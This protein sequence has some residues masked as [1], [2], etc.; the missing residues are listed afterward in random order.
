VA[1]GPG[2][3]SDGVTGARV[4]QLK[5]VIWC[6]QTPLGVLTRKPRRFGGP[7]LPISTTFR[8]L[9]GSAWANNENPVKLDLD[10]LPSQLTLDTKRRLRLESIN[11][12]PA[13]ANQIQPQP[14]SHNQHRQAHALPTWRLSSKLIP[15]VVQA[16]PA[17]RH[18]GTR[19]SACCV[20]APA[21]VDRLTGSQLTVT[22]FA[23]AAAAGATTL[24]AA[25][26]SVGR[27]FRLYCGDTARTDWCE[28]KG[29]FCKFEATAI[30][31]P[32]AM[33]CLTTCSCVC[34][35]CDSSA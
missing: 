35:T 21:P 16:H 28:A 18:E 6:G 20:P 24:A 5:N 29:A 19:A 26:A 3:S 33:D 32:E 4:R 14:T 30:T 15:P 31:N 25:G 10:S 1:E 34:G 7:E 23:A 2:T 11:N 27:P 13:L 9:K 17:S 22:A 12:P 8:E